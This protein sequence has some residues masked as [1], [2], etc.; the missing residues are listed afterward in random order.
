MA[1]IEKSKECPVNEFVGSLGIKFLGRREA[2]IMHGLG[3]VSLEDFVTLTPEK[4][5]SL[6]G[7]AETKAKA[8]CVGIKKMYPRMTALLKAGVIVVSPPPAGEVDCEAAG[9]ILEGKSFVFTG[10]I[11]KVGEDG[12]RFTRQM[13]WDVVQQNGGTA[14]DRISKDVNYLVQADPSSQ[15]S[16]TKKAQKL[17]VEIISEQQFWSMVEEKE[18]KDE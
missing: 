8:I 3:I 18:E 16:K 15:S 17:G 1:E 14:S 12:K 11:E 4:L 6:E 13:M 7:F 5:A 2:E 10:A 9:G